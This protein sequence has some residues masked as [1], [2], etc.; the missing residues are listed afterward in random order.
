MSLFPWWDWDKICRILFGCFVSEL[1]I[2]ITY[3]STSF[4]SAT[5]IGGVVVG[6]GG[7]G[8]LISTVVAGVVVDVGG[9]CGGVLLSS[10][11]V[12][13]VIVVEV[14]WVIELFSSVVVWV[15]DDVGWVFGGETHR[16]EKV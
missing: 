5:V 1:L 8:E 10:V 2:L 14:G 12:D 9:V 15:V 6:V 3:C 16:W 11:T 4:S 13:V 7:V